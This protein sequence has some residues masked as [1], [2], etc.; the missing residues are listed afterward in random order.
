MLA[1]QAD[2]T[3]LGCTREQVGP[4]EGVVCDIDP[5]YPVD[6]RIYDNPGDPLYYDPAT[7]VKKLAK[8]PDNCG[9][10]AL[11]EAIG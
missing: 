6:L 2:L 10:D 1:V 7:L 8:L 3:R 5:N 9:V 4:L 11:W